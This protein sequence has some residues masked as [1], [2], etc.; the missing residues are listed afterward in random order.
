MP[1]KDMATTIHGAFESSVQATPQRTAII[2]SDGRRLSFMVLN[3]MANRLARTLVKM[4]V[5]HRPGVGRG[6]EGRRGMGGRVPIQCVG[7]CATGHWSIVA[8]LAIMKTNNP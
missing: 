5:P 7:V 1:S 6:G 3:R 8:M 4:G 2:C